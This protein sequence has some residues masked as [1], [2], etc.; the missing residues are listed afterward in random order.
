MLALADALHTRASVFLILPEDDPALR[1]RVEDRGHS[2]L[3]TPGDAATRVEA[4]VTSTERVDLVALDGYTFDARLQRRIRDRAPLTVVDD[5]GLPADCDLAVNPSPGGE[6]LQPAGA[7]A[8]L[9]GAGYALIRESFTEARAR[10]LQNGRA[11]RTVLVSTGAIDLDGISERVTEELLERDASVRVVRVVGPDVQ[12]VRGVDEPRLRLLIAP[13]SLADALAGA[14]VYVG[15]A[16]TTA[17]Q[18]ACVGI[19]SVINDAVAN[20]SAQASALA[21]AGCAIVVDADRLVPECLTLL[22]NPTRC[23]A[24]SDRGHALVDGRGAAR[25]A[26]AM[27]RL[28]EVDVA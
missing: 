2:V 5:L 17:V 25:V 20:Q 26:D 10:V 14:T 16:G 8:F 13:P 12:G 4:V 18:A 23:D 19:P 3:T 7:T 1:R 6:R 9:G 15:A 24:M 21:H 22:D 27:L 28:A 11:S